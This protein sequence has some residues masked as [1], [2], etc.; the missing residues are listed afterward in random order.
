MPKLDDEQRKEVGELLKAELATILKGE[1]FKGSLSDVVTETTNAIVNA[2]DK[3]V[4]KERKGL[5]DTIEE[6]KKG[7]S[8][9]PGDPADPADPTK[10]PGPTRPA[11]LSPEVQAQIDKLTRAN[12]ALEEQFKMEREAREKIEREREESQL[13]EMLR[14]TAISKEVGVAPDRVEL[15]VDHLRMRGRVRKAESGNGYQLRAP[16]DKLGNEVWLPLEKGLLDFVKTPTGKV[17]LPPVP[18]GG[19]GLPTGAGPGGG[20]Q[21]PITADQISGMTPAAIRQAHKEG[22]FAQT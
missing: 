18:G 6:L 16:D 17:F 8:K 21:T 12:A 19:G 20:T 5:S 7:I 11:A 15:L 14:T 1:D 4:A 2:Y 3:R 22:K 10:P 9:S 13:V